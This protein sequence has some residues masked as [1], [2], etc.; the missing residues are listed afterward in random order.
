V[1]CPQCGK[2]SN[3]TISN[4]VYCTNCGAVISDSGAA[5]NDP[6]SKETPPEAD[7]APASEPV[8]TPA[9]SPRMTDI[10]V[11]SA[12]KAASPV[13]VSSTDRPVVTPITTARTMQDVM[14]PAA[15]YHNPAPAVPAETDE[16]KPITDH[17][18]IP[19]PVAPVQAPSAVSGPSSER[20]VAAQA[21]PKS[22][23]IVKF[24]EPIT[25]EPNSAEPVTAV[26]APVQIKPAEVQVVSDL[27][28]A[29][30]PIVAAPAPAP[31]PTP[32]PAPEP[33]T[34][35]VAAPAPAPMPAPQPEPQLPAPAATQH[36]A[37]QNLVPAAPASKE[38][39]FKLAME[40][41]TSAVKPNPMAVGAAALAVVVMGGYIWL[42]NYPRMQ[43]SAVAG[44]AG[45]T[46]SLPGYLPSSY[47]LDGP[48]NATTGQVSL[49]YSASGLPG[50]TVSQKVTSWDSS[51]LAD[52]YVAAQDPSFAS[53]QGKGL[54]VYL[55]GNGQASWV[56][57]GI[58][59]NI[60]GASRLSHDQLLKLAYSL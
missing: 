4:K 33:I 57:H 18:A 29:A 43:L 45:F 19:V 25:A 46:A 51:S 52:N 54:T 1:K 10:A 9:A 55:F 2:S 30:T 22:D 58:W 23:S 27:P 53:V 6:K 47:K 28:A 12:N 48:I 59:Y 49:H 13:P 11:P 42:Q 15:A 14:R 16:L 7:S 50:I 37:M 5:S 40:A 17:T 34:Q 35:I 56:N 8:T 32:E 21:V 39:A 44:K 26:T 38:D 3:V 60:T 36:E 31:A 41:A 20:L 24:H